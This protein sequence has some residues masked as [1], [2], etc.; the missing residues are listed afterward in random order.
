MFE[1]EKEYQDGPPSIEANIDRKFQN[2]ADVMF[3][4]SSLKHTIGKPYMTVIP[5]YKS[6]TVTIEGKSVDIGSCYDVYGWCKL[7]ISNNG[8]LGAFIMLDVQ[9]NNAFVTILSRITCG[10]PFHVN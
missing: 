9:F 1:V 2:S 3:P 8:K 10:K 5:F 7:E 4:S 6:G